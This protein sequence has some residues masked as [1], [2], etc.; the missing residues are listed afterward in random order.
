ML[1]LQKKGFVDPV[2][3][4]GFRVTAVEP[5]DLQELIMLRSWLEVPA[6]QR[7]AR[8][9][10]KERIGEFRELADA[11]VAAVDR[12]DMAT[13]LTADDEF[14]LAVLKLTGSKRL[15]EMVSTLRQQT[16][17][18]NLVE[19]VGT[20]AVRRS[21]T[22]HHQMLDLLMEGDEEGLGRLLVSHISLVLEERAEGAAPQRA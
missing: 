6:F 14:H 16:R 17:M 21:A 15:I 2:R 20:S 19:M 7:A 13:W 10:P 11:I 1:D 3:N 12:G 5:A 4:K 8:T 22:E 18:V 9:F